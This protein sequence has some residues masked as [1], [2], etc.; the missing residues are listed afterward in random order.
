MCEQLE[1]AAHRQE[2]DEGIWEVRGGARKIS[3]FSPDVLGDL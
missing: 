3:A 1:L 2:A